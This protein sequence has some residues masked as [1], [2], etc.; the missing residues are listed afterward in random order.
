[1]R[2]QSAKGASTV[3]VNAC[4][5][6]HSDPVIFIPPQPELSDK[7]GLAFAYNLLQILV[8]QNLKKGGE[9]DM[10]GRLQCDR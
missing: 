9:A 6:M 3:G 2:R 8:R 1:M 5:A 10:P 4:T 7:P